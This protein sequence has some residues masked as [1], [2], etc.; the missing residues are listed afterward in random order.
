MYTI[1]E[2]NDTSKDPYEKIKIIGESWSCGTSGTSII[3]I[4][5]AQISDNLNNN[6]EINTTHWAKIVKDE[7]GTFG[8]EEFI[9]EDGLIYNII[10][11]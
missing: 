10:C 11:H 8:L 3:I 5:V 2:G 6:T 7:E 9:G 1:Y 4:G